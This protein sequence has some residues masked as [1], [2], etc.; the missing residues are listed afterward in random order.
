MLLKSVL[1][2]DA[3]S[4]RVGVV[5]AEE[6]L[7]QIFIDCWRDFNC[8]ILRFKIYLSKVNIRLVYGVLKKQLCP[9]H[10][11]HD[12]YFGDGQE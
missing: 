11:M 8:L 1:S 2:E 7:P 12:T 10:I 9:V 6:V 4:E 5:G 3:V